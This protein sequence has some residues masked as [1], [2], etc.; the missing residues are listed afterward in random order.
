MLVRITLAAFEFAAVHYMTLVIGIFVAYLFF[1]GMIHLWLEY[2]NL[3]QITTRAKFD[4]TYR[5]VVGKYRELQVFEKLL[6]SCIQGRICPAVVSACPI[7]EILGGFACIRLRQVL[8]PLEFAFFAMETLIVTVYGFVLISGA[9]KIYTGSLKWLRDCRAGNENDR[10][11]RRLLASLTPLKVRF[12]QN[13]VDG[14]TP[15]ILQQF[16]T[17]QLANLL[18]VF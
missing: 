6:N 9:G 18:L 3:L 2:A 8:N 1:T 5:K 12:G 15:L 7:I 16:C 14:F 13:F 10:I 11:K 17:V 4:I